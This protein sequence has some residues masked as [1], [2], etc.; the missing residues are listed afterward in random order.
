[1][2]LTAAATV[3][4]ELA[5]RFTPYSMPNSIAL[6]MGMF[7]DPYF[8]LAPLIGLGIHFVWKRLKGREAIDGW[9]VHMA[10]GLITGQQLPRTVKT[11]I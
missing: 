7:L 8:S 1:M 10:A 9:D 2:G 3:L 4:L 11:S 6:A 5:D